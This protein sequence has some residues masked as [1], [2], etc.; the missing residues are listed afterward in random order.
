[1]NDLDKWLAD[2]A[3]DK[4]YWCDVEAKAKELKSDG[5]S[6]VP[7]FF[8]WTCKEHDCH[9][10]LHT[11]LTGKK[12]DKQTADYILRVRIQQGSY[13]GAF[14]PMSWWRWLGVKCL[15]AAK[16]AWEAGGK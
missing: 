12:I 11:F 13:F 1:M 10:R 15:P 9:Y 3:W 7:D 16:R 6:G 2:T 5:C 14:S 4:V 8:F